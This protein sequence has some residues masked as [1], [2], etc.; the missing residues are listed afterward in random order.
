MSADGGVA[1][2]IRLPKAA[3]LVAGMAQAAWLSADG[4]VELLPLPEAARRARSAPPLLCHTRATV[5]RLGV[6]P[7]PCFD[8]L[9][10]FAFV[11]PAR[12][13]V[14]TPRGVAAALDLELPDGADLAGAAAALR[15]GA[16]ALLGELQLQAGDGEAR[17]IAES[18]A[19]GDWPWAEAV[20]AVLAPAPDGEAATAA[21]LAVWNRLGE[22]AEHAPEPPSANLPV[23]EN[24]ARMRLAALVGDRA[25]PRPQQA[26][27]AAACAY[28][29]APRDDADAPRVLLAE[30]GTGVGKTLGY[31]ASASV[32]AEKNEG[33]VWISTYTRNLQHQIAGELDRLYP[34]PAVKERRVVVRKGRE[35]YLCLLNFEDGVGG[36]AMRPQDVTASGL[37]ARWVAATRDG[38]MVGGDLPGWLPELVGRAATLGLT[39]Q[40]GEC[41]H[42]ACPHYHR[43]FIEK[44]VRRAR[45]ARIVVANHALVMIQ[46]A[47]GGLDDDNL[48]RRYV[49]DEGHHVFAAADGAFSLALTGREAA[50]LRRWILGA[51]EGRRSRARGLKRRLDDLL[52]NDA[53]GQQALDQA[54]DGARDV[55]P[56]EGWLKRAS[57]GRA[58]RSCERFLALVRDQVLARAGEADQGYSLETEPRPPILGLTTAAHE[59]ATDLKRIETPLKVLALRLRARLGDEAAKL[60]SAMRLR[61]EPAV[62]GLER[63]AMLEL[64]GWRRMLDELEREPPGDFVDWLAVERADGHA[65]DVGMY[66]HFVDPTKPFAEFVVAPAHGVLVTSATL[67]DGSGDA[68]A[69]WLGAEA[70]SGARHLKAPAVRARVKSPFDYPVQTRV[71]I[72]NDIDRNDIDQIA[73]AYRE[74]ILASGGGALGLFTA[75]QRLKAVHKRIAA[76]LEAAGLALLAQHVDAMDTAT[77]VDIFRAEEDSSLL[78]TDAVRDGVD[79]PGRSLRLIVFDRVPWPRPDILHRARKAHF[80]AAAYDDAITRLRLKQAF[81]RLVRRATDHG[82]FVLLDRAIPSRLL[83]AFPDGV[84]VARVGLKAAIDATADFLKTAAQTR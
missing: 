33:A 16:R 38:D 67:T 21:G 17:A 47:L 11:R 62:R 57:E 40:R 28:A 84:A 27:Y 23:G 68:E 29:F 63:R 76:P 25:E 53:T 43:C 36:L 45:R 72:V 60:D 9:E 19:K 5:R 78:G 1:R 48:P 50:E 10:L 58:Q 4:E 32:W 39:D 82:I 83:G 61:I 77:L 55:L 3:S 41:V 7:F 71:F 51:E 24:E 18:M 30:A 74:L 75:I 49:F 69:D 79:V 13:C 66:R 34:D 59:L 2:P 15:D 42:S 64:G 14:P 46:A 52:A 20:R 8:L 26:D 80:G 44:S 81:G 54:I 31:I 65:I 56:A 35:N 73:A 12:F 70:R 6:A 22:W 37:V